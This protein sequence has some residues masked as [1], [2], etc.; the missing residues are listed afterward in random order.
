MRVYDRAPIRECID[1]TGNKKTIGARWVDVN[2]GT[3][4]D[5]NYRS[6]LVAKEVKT[7]D[8]PAY[9]SATPPLEAIRS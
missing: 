2:T 5:P 3:D 7:Y 8:Q 1:K 9:F 6:R 4:Q